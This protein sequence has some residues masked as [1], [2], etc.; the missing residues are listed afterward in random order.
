MGAGLIIAWIVFI[1]VDTWLYCR[2]TNRRGPLRNNW[3]G[4]GYVE[5]WRGRK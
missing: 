5:W 3:P 4:S 2:E 1:V